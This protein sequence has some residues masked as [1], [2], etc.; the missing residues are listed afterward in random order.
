M[1]RLIKL[2]KITMY[3]IMICVKKTICSRG[4]RPQ[5]VRHW[6]ILDRDDIRSPRIEF[7]WVST[8]LDKG[9]DNSPTPS[10]LQ[11]FFHNVHVITSLYNFLKL[12]L[13][14]RP[15]YTL[16]AEVFQFIRDG[17]CWVSRFYC[18]NFFTP[19]GQITFSENPFLSTNANRITNI[20]FPYRFRLDWVQSLCDYCL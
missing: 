4:T 11:Y 14:K 2:V 5:Q 20:K 9:F 8:P 6:S 17:V 7:I 10:S 1:H 12:W 3:A 13:I 19:T 16:G 15:I 18:E